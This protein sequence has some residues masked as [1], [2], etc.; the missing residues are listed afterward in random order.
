MKS[1]S[2][3]PLAV[4]AGAPTVVGVELARCFA[5]QGYDLVVASDGPLKPNALGVN[6]DAVNVD[7]AALSGVD[8]LCAALH[9]RKVDVLVVDTRHGPGKPFLDQD[10]H[11]ARQ[12]IDTNLTATLF[13][14]HKIGN[15][16]RMAGSGRILITGPVA[17]FA[18]RAFQAVYNGT[19][20]FINSFVWALRNELND[21]GVTVTCLMDKMDAADVAGGFDAMVL[22]D[23]E[24]AAPSSPAVKTRTTI[25]SHFAR[26]VTGWPQSR[27]C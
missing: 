10:F 4:I 1:A 8:A 12:V 16:M 9:D 26:P 13:L 14:I 2:R 17:G 3:R 5:R 11:E 19:K 25:P 7:M 20:A 15:R 18:P 6:V 23:S 24:R 21:A 22:G 27:P